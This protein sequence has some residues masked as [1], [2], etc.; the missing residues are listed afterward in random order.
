LGTVTKADLKKYGRVSHATIVR[1]FGSLRR[2]LGRAGLKT[3]RFMKATDDELLAILISLWQQVIERGA[4]SA[5]KRL[6]SVRIPRLK[7]HNLSQVWTLAKGAGTS[8]RVHH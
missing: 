2:G 4:N 3:G 7:G 6:R 5:K 8:T 1:R